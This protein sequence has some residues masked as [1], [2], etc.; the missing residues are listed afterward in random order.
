MGEKPKL[1][2]T[3][4]PGELLIPSVGVVTILDRFV[5]V[6]RAPLSSGDVEVDFGRNLFLFSVAALGPV[7]GA[8]DMLSLDVSF[9]DT[10]IP[11]FRGPIVAC[12]PPG[13]SVIQTVFGPNY[14]S[15]IHVRCPRVPNGLVLLYFHDQVEHGTEVP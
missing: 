3:G 1:K 7:V 5:R 14:A 11:L 4:R 10:T 9:R 15:T 13:V 8:G 2:P 6:I 12:P